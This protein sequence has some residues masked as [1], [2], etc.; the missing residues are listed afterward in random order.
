MKAQ[1][2]SCKN[3]YEDWWKQSHEIWIIKHP[4]LNLK[5]QYDDAADYSIKYDFG[6]W[7]ENE[8]SEKNKPIIER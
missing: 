8:T 5:E 6:S 4:I 1:F 2:K 3:R 7:S